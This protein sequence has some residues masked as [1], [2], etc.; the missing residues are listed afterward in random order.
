MRRP[1]IALA[2]L[3][4]ATLFTCG[5]VDEPR[6][7]EPDPAT[8]SPDPGRSESEPAFEAALRQR[9]G[10]EAAPAPELSVERRR[11]RSEYDAAWSAIVEKGDL[12]AGIARLEEAVSLDPE[13]GEAWFEL[14]TAR[15]TRALH[16]IA[17]GREPDA[18]AAYR[19]GID[20]QR[21]ARE[22]LRLGG[23]RVDDAFGWH[24]RLAELDATL[25]EADRWLETPER[26]PEMLRARAAEVGFIDAGPVPESTGEEGTPAPG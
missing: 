13:F 26:L 2:A 15:V 23:V 1:Q 11:A 5:S 12:G 18:V 8:E 21:R 22:V 20:E 7:E 6:R 9:M 14:G 4:I 16:E 10:G 19:R 17:G 3:W 25:E 24:D